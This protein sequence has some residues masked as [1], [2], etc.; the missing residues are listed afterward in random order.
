MK[1]G[2]KLA[3]TLIAMITA[4]AACGKKKGSSSPAATPSSVTPT[5]AGGLCQLDAFGRCVSNMAVSGFIDVNRF[6]SVNLTVTDA[7]RYQEFLRHNGLCV[8]VQQTGI[9]GWW[10][11]T[12]PCHAAINFMEME[13][14]TLSPYAPSKVRLNVEAQFSGYGQKAVAK[15]ANVW[16]N[17]DGN[18]FQ[19]VYSRYVT[20]DFQIL[21]GQP[22]PL[23]WPPVGQQN[24]L[25]S[26]HILLTYAD[27][28]RTLLNALVYYQGTQ[29]ASG[30]FFTT[31]PPQTFPVGM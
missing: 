10:N 25:T 17:I 26:L 6:R 19:V 14:R 23:I 16:A 7:V 12:P 5:P 11:S 20:P 3:V 22:Q 15:N 21:Q 4:L 29:I 30:Q 28:T 1:N 2:V 13:I 9:F 31:Q 27:S 8:Q 24:I 18:G